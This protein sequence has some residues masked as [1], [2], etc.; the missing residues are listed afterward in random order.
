MSEDVMFVVGLLLAIVSPLMIISAI[1]DRRW[2]ILGG[3]IGVLAAIAIT[4]AIARNPSGYSVYDIPEILGR[5]F[6]QFAK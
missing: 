6:A 2:P 1:T 5:V 4:T 3:F